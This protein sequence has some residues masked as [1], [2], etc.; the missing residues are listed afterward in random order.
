MRDALTGAL[1]GVLRDTG[2]PGSLGFG[3]EQA[4]L[5]PRRRRIPGS[6]A[7]AKGL[8]LSA[9]GDA[10]Q[11]RTHGLAR[12]PGSSAS[13]RRRRRSTRERRTIRRPRADAPPSWSR[14]RPPSTNRVN[15]RRPS[16]RYSPREPPPR[17]RSRPRRPVA[18]H[19]GR[20]MATAQTRAGEG[21]EDDWEFDL[22]P[23]VKRGARVDRALVSS[24]G[25]AIRARV[26]G[27][28]RVLF[29]VA[30]R[31]R[32]RSGSAGS[33]ATTWIGGQAHCHT[34]MPAGRENWIGPRVP[35]RATR[36]Q[37]SAMFGR[38]AP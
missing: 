15:S 18:A 12:A 27:G 7:R 25:P 3:S 9:A 31:T 26:A 11:I 29:Q 35:S 16:T 36:G 8:T 38:S 1:L 20:P 14:G 6:L 33:R 10:H 2:Q 4:P 24:K 37:A 13:D 17:A 28:G 23:P 21:E 34:L 5:S 32:K 22:V 30:W 19:S